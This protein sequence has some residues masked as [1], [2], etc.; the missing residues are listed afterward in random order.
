MPGVSI[1]QAEPTLSFR[2]G[3]KPGPGDAVPERN[4]SRAE[5]ARLILAR[6]SVRISGVAITI[7]ATR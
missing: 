4:F 1:D 7:A 3:M 5:I 2:R 6:A